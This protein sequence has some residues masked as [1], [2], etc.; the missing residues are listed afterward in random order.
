MSGQCL[1]APMGWHAFFEYRQLN[2]AM[3]GIDSVGFIMMAMTMLAVM[4]IITLLELEHLLTAPGTPQHPQR[5]HDDQCRGGKLEVHSAD[6][7][8]PHHSGVRQRR[9]QPQQNSLF[10][11]ATDGHDEGRHHGF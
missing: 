5:N 3:A 1:Q 2:T 9:G 4:V 8:Q 11:R 7:D 6:G 10:D